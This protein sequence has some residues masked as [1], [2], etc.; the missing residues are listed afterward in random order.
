MRVVVARRV[1]RDAHGRE[2]RCN[3][4]AG[5]LA[6]DDLAV[7][8]EVLAGRGEFFLEFPDAQLGGSRG[9]DA[10]VV[11]FRPIVRLKFLWDKY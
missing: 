7:V 5:E 1:L 4:G 10:V 6:L 8:R 9:A 3:V 2:L 11:G